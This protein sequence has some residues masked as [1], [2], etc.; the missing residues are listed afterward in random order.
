MK[1][2]FSAA[3]LLAALASGAALAEPATFDTP[4]AAIDAM[5][6]ALEARDREALIAVFGPENEDVVLSGDVAR[7][8]ED[9]GGFL[10]AWREMNRLAS[11]EEGRMRLYV[12]RDQWPFPVDLASVEGGWAFDAETARDEILFRRIGRNELDVIEL[13]R[14]YVAVQAEYRGADWDGDGVMEFAPHLISS[15]GM[16]D[17]LYWPPE[18]GAPE[19]PVGDFVARAAA[20]GYAVGGEVTEPEPY[21]GYYFRIL[22]AQGPAAPGGAYGYVLGGNMVA[23]HALLA[24]PA[25]YGVS[26]VTS[27]LVS[28]AG[29][30]FEAD[31]GEDTLEKAVAI[32]SFDPGP[33]WA[34]V[35]EE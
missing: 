4:Q 31:L 3:A 13:A 5:I 18:E 28:E 29:V 6:A 26:G 2:G 30:V 24:V 35:E 16:R 32:E 15:P 7:D 8:T 34:P 23:G 10:E 9:W 11:P 22:D 14:A 27:F 19:S 17:G 33:D 12:G 20:Q 25:D 1:A 21:L